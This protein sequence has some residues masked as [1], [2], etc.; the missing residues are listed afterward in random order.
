MTQFHCLF[1]TLFKIGWLFLP[2]LV[3]VFQQVVRT[4][5]LKTNYENK[6]QFRS[7]QNAVVAKDD[8][9]CPYIQ[10][11]KPPAWVHRVPEIKNSRS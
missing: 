9:T 8:H 7:V 5:Y 6:L 2:F 1:A 3:L 10:H 4:Q 11:I